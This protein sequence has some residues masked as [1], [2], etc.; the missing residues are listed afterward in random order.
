MRWVIKLSFFYESTSRVE[1]TTLVIVELFWFLFL[2]NMYPSDCI[3]LTIRKQAHTLNHK[4]G[5]VMF[6]SWY[7]FE[8]LEE[9]SDGLKSHQAL[10]LKWE[11]SGFPA[12]KSMVI[13]NS[14]ETVTMP[15]LRNKPHHLINTLDDIIIHPWLHLL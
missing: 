5:C 11:D 9:R 3:L 13:L 2:M 10:M 12:K 6:L 1:E 8:R 15:L 14:W 4:P 7:L